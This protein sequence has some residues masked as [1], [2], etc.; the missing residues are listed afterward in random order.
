VSTRG[1]RWTAEQKAAKK[2][3][4][5]DPVVKA[6][7]SVAQRRKVMPPVPAWTEERKAAH[8]VALARP[9]AK[10]NQRAAAKIRNNDP[11][12]KNRVRTSVERE[13]RSAAA[14]SVSARPGVNERRSESYKRTWVLICSDPERKEEWIKAHSGHEPSAETKLLISDSN[15]KAWVLGKH[16]RRKFDRRTSEEGITSLKLA[17]SR[18][19]ARLNRSKGQGSISKSKDHC[20]AIRISKSPE[21]RFERELARLKAEMEE[22]SGER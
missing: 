1:I 5:A 8:R 21:K 22:K 3:R 13:K 12:F 18:P 17:N 19:E 14:R 16:P 6:N 15:K 4:D 10:A 20:E 11:K 2:I 7:R 9:E